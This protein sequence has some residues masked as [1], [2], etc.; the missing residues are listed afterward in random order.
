M[1]YDPNYDPFEQDKSGLSD[2]TQNT[3]YMVGPGVNASKG[4]NWTEYPAAYDAMPIGSYKKVT[5]DSDGN[6]IGGLDCTAIPIGH[7]VKLEFASFDEIYKL[8][9]EGRHDRTDELG[10]LY[11]DGPKG[12]YYFSAEN[13]HDG[14][15]EGNNCSL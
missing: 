3:Q 2:P 6:Y 4:N 11:P 10:N 14:K 1:S 5:R 9:I 13:A 15:C 8:G 12:I 7:V